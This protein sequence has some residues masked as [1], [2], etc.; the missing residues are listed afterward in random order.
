MRRLKNGKP[1]ALFRATWEPRKDAPGEPQTEL[2]PF[3]SPTK[4]D[5]ERECAELDDS[6]A[7]EGTRWIA[8]GDITVKWTEGDVQEDTNRVS[9]LQAARDILAAADK[10]HR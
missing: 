10:S 2:L 4:A 6:T 7:L 8:A 5:L 3:V 1:L 9:A